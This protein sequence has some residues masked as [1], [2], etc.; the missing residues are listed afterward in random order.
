MQVHC[1]LVTN[2]SESSELEQS[3]TSSMKQ[4]YYLQIGSKGQQKP[5][6]HYE[7]VTLSIGGRGVSYTHT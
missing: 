3:H 7:P 5:T 6:I 4:A 1:A 2:L